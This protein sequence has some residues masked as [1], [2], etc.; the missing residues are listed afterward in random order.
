MQG[1]IVHKTLRV[2][3][4]FTMLEVIAVIVIIAI[5]VAIA[6]ARI[7]STATYGTMSEMDKVRSHLRYAQGRAMRTDSSWGI[8]FNS[9]TI[10]W[11]F[12][13]TTTN[14]I[15]IAGENQN[16]ITL[17]SLSI[18]SA[19]QAITFDRFGSPGSSNITITTSGG[20]ITVSA[21][22]GFVQ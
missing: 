7:S 14:Q 19:P 16:Q 13:T 9:G 8:N 21:N 11:L 6:V 12:Q 4:G 22:T 15:F 5:I 20:N 3:K 18:T 17:S 1:M 2:A 10:Y